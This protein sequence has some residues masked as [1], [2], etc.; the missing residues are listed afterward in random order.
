MNDKNTVDDE[1]PIAP[2]P[3]YVTYGCVVAALSVIAWLVYFV[4]ISDEVIEAFRQF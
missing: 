4:S 2:E 1:G 3:K